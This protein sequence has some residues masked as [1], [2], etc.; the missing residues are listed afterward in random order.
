MGVVGGVICFRVDVGL[1]V[2]VAVLWAWLLDGWGGNPGFSLGFTRGYVL[3]SLRD[4]G[5]GIRGLGFGL[6]AVAIGIG[7]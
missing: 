5:T 3:V 1:R 4:F 2:G 7:L 6:S